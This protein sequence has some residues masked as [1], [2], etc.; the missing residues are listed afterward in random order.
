MATMTISEA[1]NILDIV[2]AALQA[3]GPY[4]PV[5]SLQGYD[6]FQIDMAL[7][8]RIANEF[9]LLAGTGDFENEFGEMLDSYSGIP[10]HIVTLFV[11]DAELKKLKELP[12]DSPEYRRQKILIWP[13]P[14]DSSTKN[15]KDERL[16]SLE[17]PSS[18]GDYCKHVGAK[19]LIY[20]QRIY[21]RIGLEY[22]DTAPR[23]N[24]PVSWN[25]EN[26]Y[27][28]SDTSL[29]N[30]PAPFVTKKTKWLIALYILGSLLLYFGIP[31]AVIEFMGTRNWVLQPE[32]H[33]FKTLVEAVVT[34]IRPLLAVV[35]SGWIV[36]IPALIIWY[37][38]DKLYGLIKRL[39]HRGDSSQ[40]ELQA[41]QL[42]REIHFQCPNCESKYSASVDKTG[43]EGKCK[44]CGKR[45][46]VPI[47]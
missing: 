35:I 26:Q 25:E 37:I 27:H 10:L 40:S 12:T 14:L 45:L 11:A 44:K 33:L 1:E 38:W 24:A 39:T 30:Q 4:H 15:F 20:W 17:T 43:K 16:A 21:T 41:A 7:K 32:R 31:Q 18:F 42:G 34:L 23:G 22:T 5:S 2:S 47:Q 46:V 3:S 29:N 13:S 9:L 8:L 28:Q 36:V 6:V 19:D